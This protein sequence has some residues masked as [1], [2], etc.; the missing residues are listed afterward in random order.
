MCYGLRASN[1][2]IGACSCKDQWGACV[3]LSYQPLRSIMQYH[4]LVNHS[5]MQRLFYRPVSSHWGAHSH[6]RTRAKPHQTC[7]VTAFDGTNVRG[8]CLAHGVYSP[9]VA[10]RSHA[11]HPPSRSTAASIGQ[12]SVLARI[13][14]L[15]VFLQSPTDNASAHELNQSAAFDSTII[16]V[17]TQ[18]FRQLSG[19]LKVQ[20][21]QQQ[22]PYLVSVTGPSS[23]AAVT[24]KAQGDIETLYTAGTSITT[25]EPPATAAE[26]SAAAANGLQSVLSNPNFPLNKDASSPGTILPEPF[27]PGVF[28]DVYNRLP[29]IPTE[30][31][32]LPEVTLPS[33][34]QVGQSAV[35]HTDTAALSHAKKN[36]VYSPCE[37][38]IYVDCTTL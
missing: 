14:A 12:Q 6:S 2:R 34:I 9:Q 4:T 5:G 32:P 8:Q 13:T 30:F 21:L 20:P 11:H 10:S 24:T 17:Q 19:R 1:V 31:P 18:P 35:Q 27:P 36:T 25:A 28:S 7:P 15:T 23:S 16:N 3:V 22:A 37:R 26:T 29:S 38:V 33:F